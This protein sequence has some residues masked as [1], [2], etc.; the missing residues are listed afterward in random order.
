M[1]SSMADATRLWI[2]PKAS[3]NQSGLASSILS[4]VSVMKTYSLGKGRK[5]A[6]KKFTTRQGLAMALMVGGGMLGMLLMWL[7]GF[8]HLD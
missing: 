1:K 7:F 4:R 3:R 5:R 8:F 2:E 6:V